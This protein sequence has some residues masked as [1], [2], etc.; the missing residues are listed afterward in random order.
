MKIEQRKYRDMLRETKI[1]TVSN[2]VLECGRDMKKLYKG[3]IGITSNN[4][5]NPMP[6]NMDD[7]QLAEEFAEFFMVKIK[8][9]CE[10]LDSHPT[11]EPSDIA[12]HCN[13]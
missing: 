5:A 9:I 8:K 3:I 4:P 13:I 12:M 7:K 2:L 10:A 1:E 6:D 11:H